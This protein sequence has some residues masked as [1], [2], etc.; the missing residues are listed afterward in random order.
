MEPS[1][2][3]REAISQLSAIDGVTQEMAHYIAMRAFGEPDAFPLNGLLTNWLSPVEIP[4]LGGALSI[5]ED[6]RPW[7]AY[8]AMHIWADSAGV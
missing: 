2:S 1:R 6:W 7:R 3:L 5:A 8:A 4:R